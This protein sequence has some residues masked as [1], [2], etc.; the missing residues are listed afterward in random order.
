VR[1]ALRSLE[2]AIRLE[3]GLLGEV[4]GVVVVADPVVGIAVDVA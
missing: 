2:V 3:K 4:L 1:L